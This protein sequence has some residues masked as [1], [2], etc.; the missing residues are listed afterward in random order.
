MFKNKVVLI[1]GSSRG[2]GKSIV[3]S[4]AKEHAHVIINYIN[5]AKE[6]IKLEEDLKEEFSQI[7]IKVIQADVSSPNEIQNL[8]EKVKK[9]FGKLDILVNNAG[10]LRKETPSQINW[11]YWDEI[12]DIN[13]K[14]TAI[15][16]YL[17]SEIMIEEDSAIINIASIWGTELP[18]YDANA[19]AVSKAGI[20]NLTKTLALQLAPKIRVN[21]IAPSLV[22]TEMLEQADSLM[23]E[24]IKNNVPLK[25]IAK[26]EEIADLVLFLASKKSQYIT[27]EIIKIDG[28][29]TLKI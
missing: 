22:Q 25:R 14:G 20:T 13:L 6:A 7:E 29:L 15:C 17:L 16:S 1:T 11:Q 4:F 28:G 23:T 8:K 5:S 2:I 24:W 27:G 19:Y 10:I 12:M 18:A 26:P 9:Q 3:K 21:A